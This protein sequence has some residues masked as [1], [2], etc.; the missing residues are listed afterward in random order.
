MRPRW[1]A[2]MTTTVSTMQFP[3]ALSTGCSKGRWRAARRGVVSSPT[4]VAQIQHGKSAAKKRSTQP[5]KSA[6]SQ[7]APLP[8]CL[9]RTASPTSPCASPP[10][11]APQPWSPAARRRRLAA[12]CRGPSWSCVFGSGPSVCAWAGQQCGSASPHPCRPRHTRSIA[13]SAVSVS[14]PSDGRTPASVSHPIGR[15]DG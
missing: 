7:A 11:P 9:S 2:A 4:H 10:A 13:A 6:A 14:H 3:S 15:T 8:S 1:W 12:S 5:M